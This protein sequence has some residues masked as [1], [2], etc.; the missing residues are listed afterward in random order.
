M[1]EHF[2]KNISAYAFGTPTV[3]CWIVVAYWGPGAW[4]FGVKLFVPFLAIVFSVVLLVMLHIKI[5]SGLK[6]DIADAVSNKIKD[7]NE[8]S[9]LGK[10]VTA[11]VNEIKNVDY[12]LA[13]LV[14]LKEGVPHISLRVKTVQAMF[15]YILEIS[16]NN[17]EKLKTL[18]EKIGHNFLT[19]SWSI[20]DS[21]VSGAHITPQDK[22]KKWANMEKTAG[23]GEFIIVFSNRQNGRFSGEITIK[24]CFLSADRKSPNS[25][26][27]H[28]LIGY[29]SK[30][31]TTFAGFTV[32]VTEKY[33]GRDSEENT[34]CFSFEPT[35]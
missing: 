26:L 27:C 7:D 19:Y 2:R 33:C 15:E 1:S 12:R 32:T 8:K 16:D 5:K 20:M 13:G 31:I 21:T 24:N 28:F 6:N 11:I 35:V 17:P 30:I 23:W 18:G 4:D 10:I 29:F 14:L 25:C 9:F 22:I 34:C 3:L